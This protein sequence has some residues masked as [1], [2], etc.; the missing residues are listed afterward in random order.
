[1]TGSIGEREDSETGTAIGDRRSL[2]TTTN[3]SGGVRVN[4]APSRA[5]TEQFRACHA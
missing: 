2:G 3:H 1:L 4:P 5:Y